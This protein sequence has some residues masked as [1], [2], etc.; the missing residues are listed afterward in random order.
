MGRIRAV[1]LRHKAP[2]EQQGYPAWKAEA[3]KELK[4]RHDIEATAIAERIWTQ[5]YVHRLGARQAAERA[6]IVYR[7]SRPPD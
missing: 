5:F 6:S 7:T 3:A 4:D 2:N 1:P